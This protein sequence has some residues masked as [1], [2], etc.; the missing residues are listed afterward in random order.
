MDFLDKRKIKSALT[1]SDV[2]QRYSNKFELN[3]RTIVFLCPFHRDNNLGSCYAYL[4]AH[5]FTC[6]SCHEEA[7]VLKL[8]SAYLNI[9]LR[10]MNTLLER[11]AEDFHFDR[12]LF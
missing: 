12:H 5:S 8:A 11:I 10:D 7:D 1:I 3:K 9:P 6:Q 4:D 2:V